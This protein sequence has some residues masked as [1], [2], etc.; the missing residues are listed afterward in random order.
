MYFFFNIK[1]Q[2]IFLRKIFS[3]SLHLRSAAE[4]SQSILKVEI[5]MEIREKNNHQVIMCDNVRWNKRLYKSIGDWRR[6]ES[7]MSNTLPSVVTIVQANNSIG[8]TYSQRESDTNIPKFWSK[9]AQRPNQFR[10]HFLIRRLQ[11]RFSSF[12][13][14][15][16]NKI[17]WN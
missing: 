12:I 3:S 4:M 10:C 16:E 15:S 14:R 8:N 17:K 1:L 9:K 5:T 6:E 11:I 13:V 2:L 7:I